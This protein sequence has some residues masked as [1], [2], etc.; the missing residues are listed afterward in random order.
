LQNFSILYVGLVLFGWFQCI[1]AEAQITEAKQAAAVCWESADC[2]LNHQALENA[3]HKI[4][5]TF[6]PLVLTK[7]TYSKYYSGN[8]PALITSFQNYVILS[9][10]SGN[11]RFVSGD[12]LIDTGFPYIPRKYV[13]VRDIK[14]I[15][16][17]NSLFACFH[18]VSDSDNSNHTAIGQLQLNKNRTADKLQWD[19]IYDTNHKDVQSDNCVLDAVG[20]KIYFIISSLKEGPK[21]KAYAQ[22]KKISLGKSYEL[23]LESRKIKLMA[24]GH[25]ISLGMTSSQH[26]QI[27]FTENGE[28]GGDKLS[29][30]QP[31]QNYGWPFKISGSRYSK[32]ICTDQS[33]A[34]NDLP[35]DSKAYTEAVY[36]WLPSIAPSA[37]IELTDFNSAWDGDLLMGSLKAQSLYR[38]RLRNDHVQ[39][40]E[41][42]HIGHRIR[43]MKQ[44]G[45]QIVLTT[46]EGVLV[47]LSVD[48]QRLNLN[49]SLPDVIDAHLLTFCVNCHS[50]STP[51]VS[52]AFGPAL[53]GIFGR[54]IAMQN[55]A[56]FSESLKK[57]S[58]VWDE[59]SLT[60]FLADPN[61]FAPGTT[62]KIGV[63]LPAEDI[64][65]I[66]KILKYL[67]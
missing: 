65:K 29:F 58:G 17:L 53:T 10:A 43:G 55:F 23:D 64:N 54:G 1:N 9:D 19:F 48:T 50:F 3:S 40:V 60:A 32:F 56:Y 16:N 59:A 46:D 4:D 31:D 33:N 41:Q 63:K 38:I 37:L 2:G 21:D 67:K 51:D 27:W 57:K 47:K 30:L 15:E 61:S 25:R 35:T 36:S 28:R 24:V 12:S 6:L 62:M 11:M 26:G 5:S 7:T 18:Y 49:S 20:S 66:V 34:L 45:K 44:M 42:I 22:D 13:T 14:Y 52:S 8:F 39:S